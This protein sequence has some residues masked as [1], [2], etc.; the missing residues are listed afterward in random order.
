MSNFVSD[1][2]DRHHCNHATDNHH[3]HYHHYHLL[4]IYSDP[5]YS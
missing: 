2:D 3:L 4:V 5:P 1:N